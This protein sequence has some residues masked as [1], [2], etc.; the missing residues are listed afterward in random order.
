MVVSLTERQDGE[1]ESWEV[2]VQ[3]ELALHQE[4]WEI[5]KCP[6]ENESA[7]LVVE[8]LEWHVVEVLVA[9]LPSQENDALEDGEDGDSDGRRP[10]DNWVTDEIDLAVLLAPEVDAATEDW[11]G[12]WARV[13]GVRVKEASVGGPHDL[14]ELPELAEE[15]WVLVVDLLDIRILHGWVVVLLD[16]PDTVWKSSLLGASNFLLLRSPLRELDLVGEKSATSHDV[17]ESELG[18]DRTDS[19]LGEITLRLGLDDFNAKEVVG[20]S[21]ESSVAISGDLILPFSLSHWWANIVGVKASL[22]WNV[23]ELDSITILDVSWVEVVPSE[24][25]VDGV[26]RSVKWLGGVLEEPNVVLVLVWVEGNLLLLGASWIHKWVGVQVSTLSVVMS[27]ADAGAECNI[28]WRIAHALR[29]EGSLELR[30]HESITLTRVG[31]AE[32]VNGEHSHVESDWDDDQAEGSGQYVLSHES[33]GDALVVSEEDPELDNSQGSNPGDGE[34]SNPL[35]GDS[36]TES[37]SGHDKP[38]PPVWLESLG[39]TL[40]VL[41]CEGGESQCGESGAN[42]EWRIEKNE[43]CLSEKSVLCMEVSLVQ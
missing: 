3:E 34:K 42:H 27:D 32:E 39:W 5:V 26:S 17:N 7:D 33:W 18:L 43:T 41:V 10:P 24:R 14:L 20:I 23:P 35:H 4:E 37:E 12:L 8:T 28:G 19:L 13:P 36:R 38:E 30:A 40:L 22:G 21:I 16:V 6:S 9:A 31:K 15:T 1:E 2:V 29:V 25:S 11:P